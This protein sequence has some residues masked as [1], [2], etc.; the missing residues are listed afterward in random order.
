MLLIVWTMTKRFTNTHSVSCHSPI[1]ISEDA[2]SFVI[3]T[4]NQWTLI[5]CDAEYSLQTLDEEL[6]MLLEEELISSE[7]FTKNVK[8]EPCRNWRGFE[9]VVKIGAWNCSI[10]EFTGLE[11]RVLLRVLSTLKSIYFPHF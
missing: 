11:Y 9:K 7:A 2:V 6:S 8:V 10:Y 3:Q 4:S 5:Y 1:Q